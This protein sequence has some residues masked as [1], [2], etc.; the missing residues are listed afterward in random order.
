MTNPSVTESVTSDALNAILPFLQAELEFEM[1]Q[2]GVESYGTNLLKVQGQ[3]EAQT[4]HGAH[5]LRSTLQTAADEIDRALEEA[6]GARPGA[7]P[8]WFFSYT[9]AIT[10]LKGEKK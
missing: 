7:S 9:Y 6:L 10:P 1:K 5:L 4:Y 3:S 8:R 2:A